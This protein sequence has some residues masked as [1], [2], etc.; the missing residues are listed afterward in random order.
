MMWMTEGPEVARPRVPATAVAG[1]R[2]PRSRC[3]TW[4]SCRPASCSWRS[5]RS[6]RS[7]SCPRLVASAFR[8][9][10]SAAAPVGTSIGGARNGRPRAV[11]TSLNAPGMAP[12]TGS[13]PR[14]QGAARR[15]AVAGAGASRSARAAADRHG[16]GWR[17]GI[18]DLGPAALVAGGR[19]RRHGAS[20]CGRGVGRLPRLHRADPCL[21]LPAPARQRF[22]CPALDP[23]AGRVRPVVDAVVVEAPDRGNSTCGLQR[24][25]Q[26][27]RG[28][29]G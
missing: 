25:T 17:R 4:A 18:S 27:R 29:V 20:L 8:R 19:V 3:S 2:S 23:R 13:S 12:S 10:F 9:N 5:T 24:G 28:R 21:D 16:P 11:V 26:R 7:S 6:R 22:R 15:A 1:W 14:R